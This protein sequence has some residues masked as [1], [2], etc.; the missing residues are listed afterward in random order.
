MQWLALLYHRPFYVEFAHSRDACMGF[1]QVFQLLP[2]YPR[3]AGSLCTV[4]HTEPNFPLKKLIPA[5]LLQNWVNKLLS[6]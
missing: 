4:C 2:M 6:V 5:I 3:R 1:L